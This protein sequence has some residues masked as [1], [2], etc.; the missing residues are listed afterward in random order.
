MVNAHFLQ[1]VKFRQ[2]FSAS[3]QVSLSLGDLHRMRDLV[4][5]TE[6][7]ET[8]RL[9][10][11]VAQEAEIGKVE[12]P[13]CSLH[14]EDGP[15]R[16]CEELPSVRVSLLQLSER[17]QLLLANHGGALPLASVPHC[18][19][20]QFPPLLAVPGEEGVPLEHL[21]QAVRGVAITTGVTG[22][23]QLVDCS[24]GRQE[25]RNSGLIGP[26]PALASQ[27]LLF[28]KELVDLVREAPGCRLHLYKLIPSYHHM[29][30]KQ[31]RVAD[32]GFTKLR[33]LLDSLPHVVQIIGE[34]ARAVV[35]I[36]HKAQV[37]RF[38][39]DLMKVLK[40][41]QEK[42]MLLS[43]FPRAFEN[44][45]FKAFDITD[46][47]VCF[48]VDMLLEVPEGTIVLEPTAGGEAGEEFFL[49]VFRR[50]Q[51]TEELNRTRV[52]AKEVTEL[53]RHSPGF[54]ISFNKVIPSYHQHFGRQC[55]VSNYGLSKLAELFDCI[56]ETVE[57]LEVGEERQVQLTMARMV[58]VV[59]EQVEAV[60]ARQATR[61]RASLPLQQLASE[62]QQKYGH[63]LPLA[64]LGVAGVREAVALL[65]DW[66]RLG[67][68]REGEVVT[69]L[70]RGFIRTVARNVRKLLVEQG[71]MDLQ[72]F[73]RQMATRFA[74]QLPEDML[75]TDLS[76]LVRVRGDRVALSPLQLAAREVEVVLGD[77]P[78]LEVAELEEKFLARWGRQLQLDS[79]G[80]D[81]LDQLLAAL[82]EVFSVRGRGARSGSLA[83]GWVSV[84][85]LSLR[86]LVGLVKPAAPPCPAPALS[87][88]PAVAAF[89]GR[90]FD[91]LR[92]I[93]PPPHAAGGFTQ[94]TR[95]EQLA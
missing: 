49:S 84:I 83:R 56:P 50:D 77:G 10:R 93:N 35:T 89:R 4:T 37:R 51:T 94:V 81:S 2:L 3:Y 12:S 53:L 85:P 68:G 41:Q 87:P 64:R 80:L 7:A 54:S 72:D 48:L 67:E 15:F 88:R 11:L 52:F 13:H 17:I 25:F 8:G 42:R 20:L 27:L 95:H 69:V 1:L 57:V 14:L 63:C 70:D 74:C 39:N 5:V 59:G 28:T 40:L 78:G 32:Y 55:R 45:F 16:S 71:E 90:G 66:V 9:V 30:G 82:P 29:F 36:A 18:Y 44:C 26:P 73:Y 86:K 76:S 79:L 33:D 91:M 22:I 6:E 62:Y 31:C 75:V 58:A 47:G 43:L 24:S 23:K 38:T 21:L 92:L 65:R 60:V 19:A 46:Y 61:G 34:G